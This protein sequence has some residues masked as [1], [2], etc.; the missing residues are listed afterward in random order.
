LYVHP[1]DQWPAP[2]RSRIGVEWLAWHSH[3]D[4]GHLTQ[5]VHTFRPQH[6][7]L[8]HA[9]PQQAQDLADLPELCNRYHVHCP[10]PGHWLELPDGRLQTQVKPSEFPRDP[11]L[12]YEGEVEEIW[13]EQGSPRALAGVQVRLPPQ[14]AQDPRWA[15]WAETGLVE[16]RWQGSE[17]VLRGLSPR[18]LIR[19]AGAAPAPAGIV[20]R[21]KQPSASTDNGGRKC[22][23]CRFARQ[24]LTSQA[25]AFRCDQERSPLYRLRVDPQGSCPYHQ[26]LEIRSSG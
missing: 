10:Q 18:E 2:L 14:I 17:L 19:P 13:Q 6:V 15:A 5:I 3:N 9:S 16:A 8:V 25:Q 24:I 21:P 20:P 23:N 12:R 7:V 1:F 4:V 26:P 11:A 22:Q